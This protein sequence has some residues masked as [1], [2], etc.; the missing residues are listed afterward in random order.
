[1][2]DTAAAAPT[3]KF[4]RIC[5]FCGSNSGNRAVFG[6]AALELGQGLV[7][8]ADDAPYSRATGAPAPAPKFDRP[9]AARGRTP[10][11][12]DW[13]IGS[14]LSR[15]VDGRISWWVFP[16]LQVTRGIDLVYGGGSVGL[17]G[18]IAQTVL[19]GGCSVLG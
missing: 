3:R 15:G 2:G 14:L 10:P 18:L 16:F 1:M 7:S 6:D 19:D 9:G 17:M 13:V 5:V 8:N 11:F 12:L 4:G